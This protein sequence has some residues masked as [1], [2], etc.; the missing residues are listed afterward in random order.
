MLKSMEFSLKSSRIDYIVWS[1]VYCIGPLNPPVEDPG[2]C[3]PPG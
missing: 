1:M 2:L 3:D